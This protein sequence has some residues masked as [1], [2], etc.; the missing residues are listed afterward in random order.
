MAFYTP[1]KK[2]ISNIPTFIFIDEWTEEVLDQKEKSLINHIEKIYSL[3]L[4]NAQYRIVFLWKNENELMSDIRSFD[5]VWK[6]GSWPLCDVSI[7][8]WYTLETAIGVWSGNTLLVL[9][10]EELRRRNSNSL[11]E[12]LHWK[13]IISNKLLLS[14][15]FY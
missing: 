2:T 8:K 9:W 14:K 10:E 7:V 1:L 12:Y 15:S 6:R 5:K 4:F 3:K 13:P 11:E